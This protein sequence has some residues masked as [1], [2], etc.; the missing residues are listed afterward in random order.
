MTLNDFFKN[1]KRTGIYSNN[2][3]LFIRHQIKKGYGNFNVEIHYLDECI[4]IGVDTEMENGFV[5]ANMIYA[6]CRGGR[7]PTA[8]YI[9]LNKK[10][11][12][13]EWVELYAKY[14]RNLLV[15]LGHNYWID[16]F[17]GDETLDEVTRLIIA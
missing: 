14:G 4:F 16:N 12:K 8:N 3:W 9:H 1:I 6:C 13:T 17:K 7:T 2:L 10:T 15:A 5:G 11:N